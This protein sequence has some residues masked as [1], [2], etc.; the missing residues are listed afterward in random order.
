MEIEEL[1][2]KIEV[3]FHNLK[4]SKVPKI[5]SEIRETATNFIGSFSSVKHVAFYNVARAV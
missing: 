5:E 4:A 2:I 3:Y 1:N